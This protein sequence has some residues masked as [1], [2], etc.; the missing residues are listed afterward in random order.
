MS[1]FSGSPSL[2]DLSD[3]QIKQLIQ[4]SATSGKPICGICLKEFV[5]QTSAFDH[6]KAKHGGK[7][8]H[9]CLYCPLFFIT[10]HRKT[11]HISQKHREAH[12][13]NK[14]LKKVVGTCFTFFNYCECSK[15]DFLESGLL[16]VR[17][18]DYFSV[19][20]PDA[21]SRSQVFKILTLSSFKIFLIKLKMVQASKGHLR[22][23]FGQLVIQI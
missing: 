6:I 15:P 2:P 7:A 3:D 19:P 4:T 18:L 21:Q 23:N 10:A 20:N 14:L 1:V 13:M 17:I 8:T 11:I 9:Q 16:I 5:S 12:R 22:P